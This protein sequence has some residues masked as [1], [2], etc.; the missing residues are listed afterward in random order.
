MTIFTPRSPPRA[1]I[2]LL[3]IKD[4]PKPLKLPGRAEWVDVAKGFSILAVVVWHTLNDR[5]YWNEVLIFVRMPLFFFVAGLFSR[6]TFSGDSGKFTYRITNFFWLFALWSTIVFLTTT[7]TKTMLTGGDRIAAFKELAL[8][9][10]EPPQT[11]WFLYALMV[12]FSVVWLT[13][14][15]PVAVVLVASL[16]LYIWTT[17]DG[18]W[19]DQSFLDR[20]IR[21]LPF[22]II[23]LIS[24]E[25]CNKVAERYRFY[26]FAVAPLFL[27]FSYRLYSSPLLM[28]T[29]LTLLASG[30][31]I[32]SVIALSGLLSGSVAG[33]VIARAGAASLYIYVMHKIVLL[34]VAELV[35]RTGFSPVRGSGADITYSILLSLFAIAITGTA[36]VWMSRH[37]SLSFLFSV[38]PGLV[39]FRRQEAA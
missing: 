22:F 21:L 19:R 20:V 10:I 37:R 27:T 4:W 32:F 5:C 18:I 2:L 28:S 26:F 24:L 33:S 13:R 23:G 14:A 15:L 17:R 36:G 34:Y 31:G 29:P 1:G 25:Q 8:I 11:L 16:A 6:G 35:Q 7:L 12:G 39:P 38:P 30:M 3:P 9:F